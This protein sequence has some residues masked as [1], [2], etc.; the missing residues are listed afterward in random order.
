MG[1]LNHARGAGNH[2]QDVV[3]IVRDAARQ[4][5]QRLQLIALAQLGLQPVALADILH[6]ADQP[7]RAA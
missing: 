3:E 2:L 1:P 4:L 6:D 5:A 7:P